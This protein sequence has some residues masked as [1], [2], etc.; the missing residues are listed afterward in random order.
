KPVRL[1][2]DRPYQWLVTILLHEGRDEA[3]NPDG[4]GFIEYRP[5]SN[6]LAQKLYGAVP[7][8]KAAV[9]DESGYWYD[10]LAALEEQTKSNPRVLQRHRDLLAAEN[11]REDDQRVITE[12]EEPAPGSAR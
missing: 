11:L 7:T 2:P 10:E 1:E 12:N 9:Y 3:D 5:P 4:S 8:A 6:D